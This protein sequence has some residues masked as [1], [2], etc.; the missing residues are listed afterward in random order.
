MGQVFKAEDTSSGTTVAVKVLQS[1]LAQRSDSLQR[2]HKEA[3][4]LA[5]VHSPFIANLLEIGEDQGV[6]YLAMEFVAGQSLAAFLKQHGPLGER[7]ALEILCDV[8]RGIAVAHE[9]G[10]VHRDIKPENILLVANEGSGFGASES[11]RAGVQGSGEESPRSEV[12]WDGSGNTSA[13]RQPNSCSFERYESARPRVKLTDFGLARHVIESESLNLTKTGAILGT[14]LYMAPEQCSGRGAVDARADVYACGATLFHML[15]GRPPFVAEIA[16]ALIAMH[17]NDAPPSIDRFNPSVSPGLSHVIQKTLAKNPDARYANAAELLKDLERLLRGEPTS[18][19]VHPIL[20]AC[21]PKRIVEFNWTWQLEAS[22]AQLWPHVSNTERLNRAVG[23]Q[24]P[25]FTTQKEPRAVVKRMARV[26]S[27]GM[28]ITWQEHPFEW[29]E[30]QRFGVLREFSKGPFRWYTSVVE[31]QPRMSGGTSLT[32]RLK[33]EPKGLLGRTAAAIEVGIRSKR[34]LDRVYRRIDAAVT[35]RLGRG[36]AADPFE[37]PAT[38]AASRRRRLDRLLG[39]LAAHQVDPTVLE[40]LGDFLAQAPDQEVARIRPLA[41]ARRLGLPTEMLVAACLHGAREGLLVL[42]WDILCPI[43][44][45]PSEVKDTLRAIRQ[46]GHCEAC[47]LDFELDFANSVEMI[48]RAHP[49]IR[50]VELGTFCIGGPV[51]SP[52]VAVQTRVAPGEYIE[53]GMALTD[54]NYR[55]RGPQLPYAI[56]FSVRPSAN[57]N[58]LELDLSRAPGDD[59]PRSLRAASQVLA[60]ANPTDRELIVRVERTAARDDAITAARA[61]SIALFRQLFPAEILAPGQLINVATVT[62]L[63]TDLA[64]A[65]DL[66]RQHGDAGAFGIIHEHFRLLADHIAL[67][68][69]AVIKTVNE[70]LVASFTDSVAAVRVGLGLQSVLASCAVTRHLQLRVGI[71]RGPAMAATIND[72]LDYFG[73]T[74]KIAMQ[75][76]QSANGGELLITQDVLKDQL[77]AELLS[78]ANA[79]AD[80]QKIDIA[81][82]SHTV[83]GYQRTHEPPPALG[84]RSG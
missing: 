9:R 8:A 20:P 47:N 15:A 2:F 72:H 49:E 3:R 54:G 4:L 65:A 64:D 51:H 35:G 10:I 58:R 45:I 75:L 27:A 63:V 78:G 26:R 79:L 24:A 80:R 11:R 77:V 74:A 52:H 38:L 62:L 81:G 36:A 83:A 30:G 48:F 22:P 31:L 84:A 39:Q 60:L 61:A 6:L 56:Q 28:D 59:V 68:G 57:T 13:S 5:E 32:H 67:E 73:T 55:L 41:L 43:C 33:I 42:L 29:I 71:H 18:V 53:L 21:D 16:L 34:A 76:A 44:R 69:G 50:D 82:Q 7:F 66:Y 46:H 37:P 40:Q 70:G 12:A 14:P 23:L 25:D 1:E 17:C 19:A